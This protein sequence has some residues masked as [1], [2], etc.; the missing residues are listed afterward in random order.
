MPMP[1]LY[2]IPYQARPAECRKCGAVIYFGKTD[3][4]ANIPLDADQPHCEEP[5]ARARLNGVGTSHFLTCP[6][7]N[8]FSGRNK[9]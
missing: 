8:D 1:K 6:N 5:D 3:N 4:D 2:A 7:A 9:K